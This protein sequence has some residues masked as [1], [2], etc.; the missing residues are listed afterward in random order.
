MVYHKV[1]M[2][3]FLKKYEL[4]HFLVLYQPLT[5]RVHNLMQKNQYHGLLTDHLCK[6]FCSLKIPKPK[7]SVLSHFYPMYITH[8]NFASAFGIYNQQYRFV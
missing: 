5:N 1:I 7:Q 2:P 4:Y 8:L 3:Q 6:I